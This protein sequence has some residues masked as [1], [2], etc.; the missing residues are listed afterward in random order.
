MTNEEIL[1][2][3]IKKAINNGWKEGKWWLKEFGDIDNINQVPLSEIHFLLFKHNFA[4]TFWGEKESEYK[5]K[6]WD[7]KEHY[8][9]QKDWI[10]HL[11]QMVLEKEPLKYLEKFLDN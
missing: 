6:N 7:D 1:K 5:M 4:K 9:N 2:K 8:Y 11:Q 3:A 10:F